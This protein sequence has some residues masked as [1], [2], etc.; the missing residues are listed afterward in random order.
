MRLNEL[1]TYAKQE[2][3]VVEDEEQIL[4]SARALHELLGIKKRFSE[5]FR[6]NSEGFIENED[7]SGCTRKS[8]PNQNG[9]TQELQD[10]KMTLDMSKHIC[11]MSRTETGREVRQRFIQLEKDW[12]DPNKVMA[13]ALKLADKKLAEFGKQIEEMKPKAL[14]A[15][16]VSASDDCILIRELA[17]LITN[18]GV[19]I[20]QNQLYEWMRNN[21]YLIKSGSDRNRPTQRYMNMGIFKVKETVRIVDGVSKAEF[22]TK[23]TGKGQAYFINK[24][25]NN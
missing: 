4:I 9:I 21:G 14:F 17:K 10:Y 8:A 1:Q 22:V 15:D 11:M 23:I 5:W 20:G 6:V 12:N 19:K 18:N 24:F 7:F 3:L 2:F 13:R 16:A 25:L